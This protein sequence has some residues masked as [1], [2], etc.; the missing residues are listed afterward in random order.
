E[1]E[2]Y[3]A[4]VD[5]HFRHRVLSI[6]Y[7]FDGPTEIGGLVVDPGYRGGPEKP[8]K[9]L[10]YVRFLYIAMHASRFRD[11]VLVELLPKL[12]EDRRSPRRGGAPRRR[13]D[14]ALRARAPLRGR[15]ARR[16]RAGGRRHRAPAGRARARPGPQPLPGGARPLLLPRRGS[17]P[18]PRRP[19]RPRRPP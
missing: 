12:E 6:G 4:S 7:N 8:G 2:H 3:S 17:A 1:K 18:H 10:S 16:R 11:R 9:Q 14:P 5:R 15:A 19:R 13:A